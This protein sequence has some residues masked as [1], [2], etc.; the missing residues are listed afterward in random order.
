M[1]KK[2]TQKEKFRAEVRAISFVVFMYGV[3]FFLILLVL[4]NFNRMLN[5]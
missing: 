5:G 4:Q 3:A 2:L 1:K